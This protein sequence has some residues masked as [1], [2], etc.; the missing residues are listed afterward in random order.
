[1]LEG[2]PLTGS[3]SQGSLYDNYFGNGGSSAIKD[4]ILLDE[5][6][7]NIINATNQI[8]ENLHYYSFVMEDSEIQTGNGNDEFKIKNYR[9]YYAVGLKNSTLNSGSGQDKVIIELVEDRFV[10]GAFGLED[11]EI[12][13][14]SDDDE[15]EIIMTSSNNDAFT[16]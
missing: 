1:M 13:T 5:Y 9:G 14:G 16:S 11:S 6:G 10:Y 8:D 7:N 3:L 4:L 12:N 2:S 15:V